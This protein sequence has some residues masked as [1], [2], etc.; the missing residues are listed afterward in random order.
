MTRF[1]GVWLIIVTVSGLDVSLR[2]K[3]HCLSQLLNTS[4]AVGS[5]PA[6][7]S[8][9]L[10]FPQPTPVLLPASKSPGQ[11]DVKITYSCSRA[12]PRGAGVQLLFSQE[13]S[14]LQAGH[15]VCWV[16]QE[17]CKLFLWVVE[18]LS[19]NVL[20]KLA[21]EVHTAVKPS[22]RRNLRAS[23]LAQDLQPMGS[24][25]PCGWSGGIR[26]TDCFSTGQAPAR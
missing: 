5:M 7:I 16:G 10:N 4:P 21:A 13:P 26:N 15:E 24:I 23:H 9:C 14:S 20:Q 2:G 1:P 17:A 6:P 8:P 18:F 19:S 12:W 11:L 25:P 22:G 3:R